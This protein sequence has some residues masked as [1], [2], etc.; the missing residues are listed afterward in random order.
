MYS[1]NECEGY[2]SINLETDNIVHSNVWKQLSITPEVIKRVESIANEM[3]DA[4]ELIEE[5]DQHLND[6]VMHKVQK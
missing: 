5:L 1:K 3:I 4:E 2:A 6:I